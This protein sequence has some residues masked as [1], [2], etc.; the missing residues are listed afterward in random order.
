MPK[1]PIGLIIF[2]VKFF[3]KVAI[4][5]VD[6]IFFFATFMLLLV[7][8]CQLSAINFSCHLIFPMAA[9]EIFCKN[10]GLSNTGQTRLCSYIFMFICFLIHLFLFEI[11]RNFC[12][13]VMMNVLVSENTTVESGPSVL[14]IF[15]QLKPGRH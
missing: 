11:D 8:L 5:I 15:S 14:Q 4:L 9:F 12:C 10:F 7:K 2:E 13:S 3:E 6:K 1:H